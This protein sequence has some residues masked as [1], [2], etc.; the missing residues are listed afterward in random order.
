MWI[1]GF[2]PDANVSIRDGSQVVRLL[3]FSGVDVVAA[4]PVLR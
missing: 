4:T 2:V 3:G 1:F